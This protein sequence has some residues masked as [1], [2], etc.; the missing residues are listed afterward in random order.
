VA[1]P[2]KQGTSVLVVVNTPKAARD[3]TSVSND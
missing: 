3:Q 1:P 2:V